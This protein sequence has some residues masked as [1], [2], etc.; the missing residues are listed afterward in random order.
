MLPHL[1]VVGAG[2]SGDPGPAGRGR[3]LSGEHSGGCAARSGWRS[4]VAAATSGVLLNTARSDGIEYQKR[5]G[6]FKSPGTE[7]RKEARSKLWRRRQIAYAAEKRTGV[8]RNRHRCLGDTDSIR[9]GG[10]QGGVVPQE[11]DHSVV[12][13]ERPQGTASTL[14]ELF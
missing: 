5:R 13:E 6:A 7:G 1:L 12:A 9:P 11:E 4:G 14:L 8:G 10:R 2:N 3:R